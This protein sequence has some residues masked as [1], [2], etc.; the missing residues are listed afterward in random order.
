M[1]QIKLI[2]LD[3]DGTLVDTRRANALAY[4]ETLSE[5]GISLTE[6]EYL[7]SYFGVRCIEF[8]QALGITDPNQIDRLRQRKVELYTKYFNTVTLNTPLWQWCMM[9]RRMGS[10]VWIV[11]TGHISNIRNVMRH[12]NISDGIDGIIS[13][14]DVATAKPA[15]DAFLLAMERAGT[16]PQES[17]IFEDSA[18]GLEAAHRSGA[19]Y[20]KVSL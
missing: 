14:D 7:R 9:M 13:G 20:V 18:V 5:I 12:L 8:M 15:P 2:L 16:T 19:P 3:F 11:S 17:I 4:I 1:A 10:K 6:E